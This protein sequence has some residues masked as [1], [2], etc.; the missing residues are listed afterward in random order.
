MTPRNNNSTFRT[1]VP[2]WGQNHQI[3]DTLF[4]NGIAVLIH[5]ERSVVDPTNMRRFKTR[6]TPTPPRALSGAILRNTRRDAPRQGREKTGGWALSVHDRSCGEGLL[7]CV[8]RYELD[9]GK[10]KDTKSEGH[11]NRWVW[12]TQPPTH[13][14]Y[15]Y[16]Y[17][18]PGTYLYIVTR[19]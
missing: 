18:L 9:L 5:A 8:A 14:I 4:P 7:L 19:V 10:E 11:V 13:Y 2:F 6:S 16:I 3:P 17:M 12:A 15:I 1:A